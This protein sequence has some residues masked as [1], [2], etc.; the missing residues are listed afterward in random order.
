MWRGEHTLQGQV[1]HKEIQILDHVQPDIINRVE[2]QNNKQTRKMMKKSLTI[3]VFKFN[4]TSTTQHH[5]T[6]TNILKLL[7]NTYMARGIAIIHLITSK[8]Y[9]HDTQSLHNMWEC[10]CMCKANKIYRMQLV[11]LLYISLQ[12]AL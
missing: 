6:S 5:S 4:I 12:M 3:S 9:I 11:F 1:Y 8:V 7:I 2:T 10:V